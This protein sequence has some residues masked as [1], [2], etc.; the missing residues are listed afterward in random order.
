MTF[1][2]HMKHIYTIIFNDYISGKYHACASAGSIW[3]L[4]YS[5]FDVKCYK[6]NKFDEI[7]KYVSYITLNNVTFLEWI[8]LFAKYQA[9]RFLL[10]N[11]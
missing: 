4:L 7:L 3:K 5:I 8:Q 11:P 9:L 10:Y 1:M 2:S 6:K